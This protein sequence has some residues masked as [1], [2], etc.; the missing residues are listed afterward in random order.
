M[1][2]ILAIVIANL[3]RLKNDRSNVFF[4]IVLP[5][6][7]VLTLGFAFGGDVNPKIGVVDPIDNTASRHVRAAVIATDRVA[8]EDVASIDELRHDVA[9]NILDGGWY[10]TR[11]GSGDAE[12]TT[13]VWVAG[14]TGNDFPIRSVAQS[15]A[16]VASYRDRTIDM[17]TRLTGAPRDDASR[18]VTQSA[19]AGPRVELTTQTVGSGEDNNNPAAVRAVIAGHQI[20]LFIFLTSLLGASSLLTSR[21]YGVTRRTSA[22]PVSEAQIIA[23]EALSRYIVALLQAAVIL[24]GGLV[25][26]GITWNDPFTM[27]L[28]C[29]AM[30]LVGT[31]VAMILGTLGR[32]EQ[33]VTAVALLAGLALAALGGSMQPLEFFPDVMRTIAFAVT[34]HAWMNDSIWRILV[35]DE[36]LAQV[37]PAIVVLV[38]AGLVLIAVAARL[39]S[40]RLRAE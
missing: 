15:A 22:A 6:L 36:G 14:T 37:W 33:Q 31:G 2:A 3:K 30:G 8:M 19:E 24:L 1:N 23:G 17:V 20:T 32:S 13:V 28:L 9:R 39:L 5:L 16:R 10:V 21:Q 18:A 27:M 35:D 29:A 11:T 38:V 4:L 7:L 26:F 12:T 40:R 34:P 25:F